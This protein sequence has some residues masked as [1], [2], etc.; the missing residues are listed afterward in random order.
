MKQAI[1][2]HHINVALLRRSQGFQIDNSC[3]IS[4]Q[5]ASCLVCLSADTVPGMEGLVNL[6]A[7]ISVLITKIELP[8]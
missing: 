8:H 5:K 4:G 3:N 7:V 2:S 6:P 1:A